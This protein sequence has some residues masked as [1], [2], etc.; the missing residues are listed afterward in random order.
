MMTSWGRIAL[1]YALGVLGAGQLGIM[2]PLLPALQ[3]DLGMSLAV[4]GLAV[5]I[6]TLVGAVIGLPAGGWCEAIG[7]SRALAVGLLIMGSAAALC[8]MAESAAL[9]LGARALAGLGYLLVAVAGP[10]LMALSAQPRHQ[11]LALS[12]WGTF[13]PVGIALGGLAAAR[14]AGSTAWRT[15]FAL[16]GILLAVALIVSH[17]ALAPAPPSLRRERSVSW[18][19]LRAA[20]PLGMAFFCFALLFLA[21]A[22]LLPTYLVDV[23]GLPAADAARIL[24]IATAAGV[25]G[26]LAA[27]GLM[28]RGLSP[29]MLIA[30]G[31]LASTVL[32]ALSLRE[33]LPLVLAIAGF[34]AAFAVGGLVPAATFASVPRIAGDARAIGPING[35]LA[36]TGSL[37]SL[38]GPPLLALW[39]ESTSWALAPALLLAIAAIGTIAAFAVRPRR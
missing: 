9:L 13:V 24:A 6:V 23:R 29:A 30:I 26:S 35:L 31:L 34:A 17:L 14:F 2:P 28:R 8:A 19:A 22:G 4:A 18:A 20:L 15:L 27:G 38:A 12:L 36:Q 11:P 33:S 37:G 3:A 10:T 21:L 5:S 7:H 25:A 16:D 32:A 39:I 1:L